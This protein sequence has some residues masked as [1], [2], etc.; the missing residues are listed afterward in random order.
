MKKY[1]KITL[2]LLQPLKQPA[3]AIGFA[4]LIGAILMISTGEN[5]LEVYGIMFKGAF[6]STQR[7][8]TI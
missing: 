7:G 6:S 1:Y 3:M 4:F 8:A 5:P 2:N